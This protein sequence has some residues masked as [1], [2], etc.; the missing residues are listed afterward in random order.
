M[1][2]LN[3]N[4]HFFPD[5]YGGATVVA[6]KLAHGMGLDGNSVVNVSLNSNCTET[7]KKWDI[8][9]TP[10]GSSI[11]L[12]GITPSL[13]NRHFNIAATSMLFEIYELVKPEKIVIHAAQHMG[14]IHFLNNKEILKKSTIVAH[15]FFWCCYTGFRYLPSGE[16]CTNKLSYDNCKKCAFFPGVSEQLYISMIEILDKCNRLI[17]PSNYIKNEYEKIYRKKFSNSKVVSNPDFSESLSANFNQ[18]LKYKDV[19]KVGY[20]GGP[21]P[22]KGWDIVKKL[23]NTDLSVEGKKLSFILY[24][25]GSILGVSWYRAEC[26]LQNVNCTKPFHW[27]FAYQSISQLDLVLMPSRVNE[28]FGLVAREALSA[29]VKVVITARGALQELDGF[30][31]VFVL[32]KEK[33]MKKVVQHALSVKAQ[34]NKGPQYKNMTISKYVKEVLE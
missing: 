32:H 33:D 12:N 34:Q 2:I 8:I 28:S 17:F 29:G 1:N 31:N 20:F 15:D 16:Q 10:F 14:I 7:S 3:I 9:K 4:I 25:V 6:E 30:E 19:F 22:Q 21:G 5:S 24:D 11:Q 27:S 13:E 26:N 18:F 23:I